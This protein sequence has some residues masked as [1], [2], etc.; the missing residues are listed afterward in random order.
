MVV[1][2]SDCLDTWRKCWRSLTDITWTLAWNN[3]TSHS[4]Q[5]CIHASGSCIRSWLVWE[6]ETCMKIRGNAK[7]HNH[8]S[9]RLYGSIY[10][11]PRLCL[12]DN[13]FALYIALNRLW[14]WHFLVQFESI[15]MSCIECESFQELVHTSESAKYRPPTPPMLWVVYLS[16]SESL[17]RYTRAPSTKA[18]R[19]YEDEW[20]MNI[21]ERPWPSG[22]V[23][24]ASGTSTIPYDR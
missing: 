18:L 14:T 16:S 21:R 13:Q 11:D 9:S 1:K 6:H 17:E 12:I 5:C 24:N 3:S 4:R 20:R 15:S 19:W 8:E 10:I 22:Y 2:L 23:R 7:M